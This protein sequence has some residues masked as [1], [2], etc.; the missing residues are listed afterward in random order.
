ME[1]ATVTEA[2]T[3]APSGQP[4]AR[5][6]AA[7]AE[8]GV[9]VHPWPCGAPVEHSEANGY[10]TPEELN[11]VDLAGDVFTGFTKLEVMHPSD[12][13]DVAFHVHAIQAIVGIR[14]AQRAHPDRLPVKGRRDRL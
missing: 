13:G 3:P 6:G 14:A 8:P 11:V 4:C 5:C 2:A 10:L 1:G 9:V 7:M 12:A